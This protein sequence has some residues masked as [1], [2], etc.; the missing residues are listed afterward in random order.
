V[1][2]AVHDRDRRRHGTDLAQL[3]ARKIDRA[4]GPRERTRARLELSRVLENEGGDPR[5]AQRAVETAVE[6]DPL[7]QDASAELDRLAEK[8]PRTAT[9]RS[10]A[11]GS[12]SRAPMLVT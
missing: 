6:E 5:A 3:Y 7:D 2:P 12:S 4:E 8:N 10:I 11:S 9:A 1:R